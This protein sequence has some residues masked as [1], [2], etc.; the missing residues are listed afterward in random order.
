MVIILGILQGL[1]L[2]MVPNK[3]THIYLLYHFIDLLIPTST[4]VGALLSAMKIMSALDHFF[5]K[6][7]INLQQ[8]HFACMDTQHQFWQEKWTKTTF[9]A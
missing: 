5:V 9:R 2:I 1:K 4:D 8:T 3:Y 7:E 6:N